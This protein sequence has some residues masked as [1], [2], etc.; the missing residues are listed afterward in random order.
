MMHRTSSGK[1]EAAA[2]LAGPIAE[3]LL[4]VIV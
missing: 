1:D 2:R 3:K 4:T